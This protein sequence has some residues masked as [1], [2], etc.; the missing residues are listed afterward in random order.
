MVNLC[1]KAG[2]PN[3]RSGD[4]KVTNLKKDNHE[5][6]FVQPSGID[7]SAKRLV[8]AACKLVGQ[9]NIL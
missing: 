1:D 9:L 5:K 4:P 8:V 6:R 3:S 7:V 2:R